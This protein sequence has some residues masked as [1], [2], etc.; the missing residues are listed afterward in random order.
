MLPLPQTVKEMVAEAQRYGAELTLH[1]QHWAQN[2]F[3]TVGGKFG[4][5]PL[6]GTCEYWPGFGSGNA[7][8]QMAIYVSRGG[9][10]PPV[11]DAIFLGRKGLSGVNAPDCI[12]HRWLDIVE[13]K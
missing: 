11:A 12:E 5:I 3:Y 10:H 2:Y 9:P 4:D 13:G 7:L 8:I 6:I 1:P